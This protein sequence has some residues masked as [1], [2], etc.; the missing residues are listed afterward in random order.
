[1]VVDRAELSR[2]IRQALQERS[3]ISLAELVALHP[4]HLG[5]SELLAYLQLASGRP[6]TAVDEESIE[7]IEWQLEDGGYRRVRL[8]RIIFARK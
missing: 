2:H 6:N 1:M 7:S 8:P 4:L 5:L 3:Q